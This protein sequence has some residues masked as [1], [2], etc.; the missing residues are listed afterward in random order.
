V[1]PLSLCKSFAHERAYLRLTSAVH[2][3]LKRD[4]LQEF[5]ALGVALR[6][7]FGGGLFGGLGGA[8]HRT[9]TSLR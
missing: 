4:P 5:F 8:L 6:V 2:V 9:H 1:L 7:A 3:Q